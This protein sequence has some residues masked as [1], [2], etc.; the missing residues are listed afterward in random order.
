MRIVS[1]PV[2]MLLLGSSLADAAVKPLA[3]TCTQVGK[4]FKPY[5]AVGSGLGAGS[6]FLYKNSFT[7]DD[8][9]LL[10][11][12]VFVTRPDLNKTA[13]SDTAMVGTLS[14]TTD[15][16]AS[17]GLSLLSSIM[18]KDGKAK[19]DASLARGDKWSATTGPLHVYGQNALGV[20]YF[21]AKDECL[22]N[23]R[24]ALKRGEKIKVALIYQA[25][26]TDNISYEVTT[27]SAN[28]IGLE[29]ILGSIVSGTLGYSINKTGANKL[30]VTNK[31]LNVCWGEP[32]IY[33]LTAANA[34]GK[35]GNYFRLDAL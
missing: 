17:F 13:I 29:A 31:T 26:R 19:L 5:S 20:R 25:V 4:S 1:V 28:K 11:E 35:G 18:K 3:A 8:N 32:K 2:I 24:T 33:S 14:G 15:K 21:G 22:A 16:S 9:T 23:I 12:N 30:V 6:I 27:S 10:C 34:I 7:P